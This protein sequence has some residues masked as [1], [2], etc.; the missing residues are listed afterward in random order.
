MKLIMKISLR[1]RQVLSLGSGEIQ[2]RFFKK[3][4]NPN[5]TVNDDAGIESMNF[6]LPYSS[7]QRSGMA[8]F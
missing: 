3:S 8:I 2:R 6:S 7:A 1:E 4:V 5:D